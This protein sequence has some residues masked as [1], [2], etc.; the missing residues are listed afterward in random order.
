VGFA[1]AFSSAG[2]PG[3]PPNPPAESDLSHS[4]VAAGGTPTTDV[5]ASD[6]A[7]R[8]AFVVAAGQFDAAPL[9]PGVNLGSQSAASQ[10]ETWPVAMASSASDE[11]IA[12]DTDGLIGAKGPEMARG[13]WLVG[14]ALL[15]VGVLGTSWAWRSL[16]EDQS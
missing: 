4:A 13:G 11:S 8:G 6:L 16:A 2:G 5:V 9:T 12:F 14:A 7:S 15:G 1:G 3:A 10:P